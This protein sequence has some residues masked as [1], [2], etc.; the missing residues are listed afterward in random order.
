MLRRLKGDL[1][2]H[3]CLSPCASSAMLPGAIVAAALERNLGFIGICDHNAVANV[4]A[5]RKAAEGLSLTV[6]GGVE[7]TSREEVHVLA[8]FDDDRT[9]G[10]LAELIDQ[11]LSGKNNTDTFGYQWVVDEEGYVVGTDGRLLIGA[12]DLS[13]NRI[14]DAVAE[15]GGMAVAAHVDRE[16][17]GIIGQLGFIPAGLKLDALELSAAVPG[18]RR[19]DYRKF[20]FPLITASDAHYIGDVGKCCT[21]FT[22]NA[23]TVNELRKALNAGKGRNILMG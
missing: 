8:L 16:A 20:G 17:F 1:H 10:A 14:V 19:D 23:A 9:L 3:T 12:T 6:L 18:D 13:I 2:V 4:S 22:V 15:L 11:H 7:V 5:V 21:S